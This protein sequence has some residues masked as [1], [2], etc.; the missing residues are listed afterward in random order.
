MDL[1][2]F[3]NIKLSINGNTIL[4]K[5]I[6]GVRNDSLFIQLNNALVDRQ[7]YTLQIDSAFD[8]SMNKIADNSSVNFTYI[9]IRAALQNDIII[10]EIM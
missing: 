1:N 10:T 6:S 7:N 8:C 3:Q 5:T 4:S 9:P 2:S